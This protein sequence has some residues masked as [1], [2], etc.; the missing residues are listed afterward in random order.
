MAT[1][2]QRLESL[3]SAIGTDVRG[4]RNL[5]GVLANLTTDNK[6]N[7]VLAINEVDS[8]VDAVQ[9]MVGTL[10]SKIL[11]GLPPESLDTIKELA[12]YLSDNT[13]AGGVIQQLAKKLDVSMVQT[14]STAEQVQ[15]RENIGA[16]SAAV[17]TALL[18]GLGTYDTDYAGLYVA[19][20]DAA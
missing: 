5:L 12:A 6:G 1:L 7:L 10:E 4:I 18:T 19:S 17:L 3:A 11:G 15:G 14:F 2:Q 20:R 16:A 9:A 13:V 8:R